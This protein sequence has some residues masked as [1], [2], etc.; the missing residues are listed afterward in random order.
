MWVM[1]QVFMTKTPPSHSFL[2][3][4]FPS[5]NLHK[6]STSNKYLISA[7]QRESSLNKAIKE[8]FCESNIKFWLPHVQFITSLKMPFVHCGHIILDTRNLS[9][10]LYRKL[11]L[12]EAVMRF[13]NK[14][15]LRECRCQSEGC[16]FSEMKEKSPNKS[17][18][19][20]KRLW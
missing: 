17:N 15:V 6:Y 19:E 13:E 9:M 5:T 12:V 11:I 8:F 14:L 20:R 7:A 18:V 10:M 4:F 1:Q 3:H 2:C 16:D